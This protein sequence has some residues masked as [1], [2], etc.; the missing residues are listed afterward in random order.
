[1]GNSKSKTYKRVL[2]PFSEEQL[3]N[4]FKNHDRDGDGHLTKEE[5][6]QAFEYLGSRF[7]NFRVEEALR[8]ADTNGDGVISMDEMGKLIKYAKTRKYTIS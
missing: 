2:V 1:M 4:V 5:L 8:A 3:A 7:C 6:K